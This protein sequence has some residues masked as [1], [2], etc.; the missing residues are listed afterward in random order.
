MVFCYFFGQ[1]EYSKLILIM[2]LML[3][4]SLKWLH[5]AMGIMNS[6]LVLYPL[7]IHFVLDMSRMLQNF[8]PGTV[9]SKV[10]LGNNVVGVRW[11]VVDLCVVDFKIHLFCVIC[12]NHLYPKK[13]LKNLNKKIL[14][15]ISLW[16]KSLLILKIIFI[17]RSFE[18]Q[19]IFFN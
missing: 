9:R 13:N 12:K 14:K 16:V 18:Y 1:F 8:L 6:K 10:S 19:N 3:W 17:K 15:P 2:K 5:V 11:L 4:Q 7:Q